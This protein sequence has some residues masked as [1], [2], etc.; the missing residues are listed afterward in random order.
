MDKFKQMITGEKVRSCI[1]KVEQYFQDNTKTSY[2]R[3]KLY[4]KMV[5]IGVLLIWLHYPI[6]L[7]LTLFSSLQDNG[8]FSSALAIF[9]LTFPLVTFNW[10]LKN[11]D[12]LQQFNDTIKQQQHASQQQTETLFANALQLLFKQDDII[13]NSVGLKALIRLRQATTDE[14]FIERIDLIT[15]SGLQL[16]GAKLP[17]ANLQGA[18]LQGAELQGADLQWANLQGS[19][20]NRAELQNA[21][22]QVAQ[23]HFAKLQWAELEGTNLQGAIYNNW[24][25]LPKDFDPEAHGMIQR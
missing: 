14:D 11:R 7:I 13:A 24:T 25:S 4:L 1:A 23:L 15:S 5:G 10:W 3:F 22:L 19:D 2:D 6:W 17:L 21:Q 16:E 8:L 12:Q 20:L 9:L 18:N